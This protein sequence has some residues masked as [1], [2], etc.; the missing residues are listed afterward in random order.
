MDSGCRCQCSYLVCP[1]QESVLLVVLVQDVEDN[2]VG[3]IDC[4]CSV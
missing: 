2:V 1:E 4:R 3:V